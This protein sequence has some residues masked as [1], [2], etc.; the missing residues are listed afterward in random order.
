MWQ[1]DMVY[2]SDF[3]VPRYLGNVRILFPPSNYKLQNYPKIVQVPF[4][5]LNA[6]GD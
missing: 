3:V 5:S 4:K 6:H 1:Y 2:G